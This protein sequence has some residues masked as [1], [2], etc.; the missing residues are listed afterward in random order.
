[1]L[2]ASHSTA[3]KLVESLDKNFSSV[4]SC[5]EI[6]KG[7]WNLLLNDTQFIFTST[8]SSLEKNKFS[9]DAANQIF[10]VMHWDES[11]RWDIVAGKNFSSYS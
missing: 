9:F 7:I 5:N 2:V 6:W 11:L 10:C 1:V 4:F 3:V 8:S